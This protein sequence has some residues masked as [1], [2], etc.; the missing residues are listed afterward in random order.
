MVEVL[1][2]MATHGTLCNFS[3][4]V[5][6][7]WRRVPSPQG[8]GAGGEVGDRVFKDVEIMARHYIHFAVMDE[9]AAMDGTRPLEQLADRRGIA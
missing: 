1:Y 8:I 3:G 4:A 6:A 2:M 7:P 9:A 5:L